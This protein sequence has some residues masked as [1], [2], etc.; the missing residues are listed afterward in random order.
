MIGGFKKLHHL[1][2]AVLWS[3]LVVVIVGLLVGGFFL[4]NSYIYNE[5]QGDGAEIEIVN[6]QN[7]NIL[8][9]PIEIDSLYTSIANG[10]SFE[11]PD[12]WYLHGNIWLPREDTPNIGSAMDGAALGDQF[13]ITREPISA[14][15]SGLSTKE[16]MIQSLNE[17]SEGNTSAEWVKVNGT[18]Y[19]R[20]VRSAGL[21]DGNVLTYYLFD[22]QDV[23]ILSHFPYSPS[24]QYSNDFE[25]VVEAFQTFPLK[26]VDSSNWQ[27]Y[28][29]T[30]SNLSFRY[31]ADWTTVR[32]DTF[33][34]G[35]RPTD[36]QPGDKKWAAV[37]VNV[38]SNPS[39][40]DLS[41]F[42]QHG[43][44]FEN[45]FVLSKTVENVTR[46][47][48]R[49]TFFE[50]IPGAMANSAVAY[51]LDDYVVEVQMHK[52]DPPIAENLTEIF[53]EIATSAVNV[54]DWQSYSSKVA[55]TTTDWHG[56][57]PSNAQDFTFSIKYPASWAL[58]G[59]VFADENK[60]KIGELSPGL[61]NLTD[62]QDCIDQV[63]EEPTQE[64][65]REIKELNG[66]KVLVIYQGTPTSSGEGFPNY[67]YPNRYCIQGDGWAF[68]LNFYEFALGQGDRDLFD[69]I[70]STLEVSASE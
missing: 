10:Y 57:S 19:Y 60:H 13:T 29:D 61:V 41:D 58:G 17:S 65:S 38:R 32:S 12:G 52:D 4:L 66:N 22:D 62:G 8:N 3:V 7:V 25:E 54:S 53:F 11:I 35:F 14:Y 64:L 39:N 63:P 33:T 50:T 44:D 48:Q 21:A 43:D 68:I 27:T 45:L 23:F 18:E 2:P 51:K 5:K 30:G 1:P 47:N 69:N 42:Y 31:P 34:I 36:I 16:D 56:F 37:Y 15:R 24:F 49:M 55:W 20:V 70:V 40:L 26:L 9:Q 6:Q 67:W 59:S 28:A 46:N